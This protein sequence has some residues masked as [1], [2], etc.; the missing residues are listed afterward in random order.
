M[1]HHDA[2]KSDSYFGRPAGTLSDRFMWVW[3]HNQLQVEQG[4]E[5]GEHL[6]WNEQ[7]VEQYYRGWFDPATR[8]MFL[9]RPAPRP[10]QP[11]R[12]FRTIPKILDRALRRRFGDQFTY[13][14][15]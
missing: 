1:T 12:P 3:K 14:A 4:S 9:V 8:E 11:I 15:F 13:R 6:E 7:D 10:G 2:S 5:H